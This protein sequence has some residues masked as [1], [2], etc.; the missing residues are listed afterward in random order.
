MLQ[1][2]R[3]EI[4]QERL[5]LKKEA[6]GHVAQIQR[7]A[8]GQVSKIQA[9]ADGNIAVATSQAAGQITALTG[10]NFQLSQDRDRLQFAAQVAEEEVQRLRSEV[11]VLRSRTISPSE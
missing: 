4:E 3:Q 11:E 5:M 6:E 1:Q 7:Q 9:E 2:A 8:E 10:E